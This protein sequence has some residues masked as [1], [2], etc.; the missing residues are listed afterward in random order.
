MALAVFVLVACGGGG[1]DEKPP[2]EEETMLVVVESN[3][4]DASFVIIDSKG[5]EHSGGGRIYEHKMPPGSVSIA[6]NFLDNYCTPGLQTRT[7]SSG[8][9]VKFSA[10]YDLGCNA[11]LIVTADMEN[12]K[13]MLFGPEKTYRGLGKEWQIHGIP[14][15]QYTI[16][17]DALDDA[18]YQPPVMQTI[19]IVA[20]STEQRSFSYTFDDACIQGGYVFKDEDNDGFSDGTRVPVDGPEDVSAYRYPS[21]LI[22]TDGDCDDIDPSENPVSS[23]QYCTTRDGETATVFSEDFEAGWGDWS[24]DAGVWEIGVPTAG[25][26][27]SQGGSQCAGTILDGNY[28]TYTSSRLI[29]PAITLPAISGSNDLSLRFMHWFEYYPYNISNSQDF[30]EIEIQTYDDASGWSDWIKIDETDQIQGTNPG[31]SLKSLDISMYAGQ[32]V[33]ICFRH[34]SDEY[35]VRTGWYVDDV[36][37]IQKTPEFEGTFE[38][39]WSDWFA[40]RGVWQNGTPT[41]GPAQCHAGTLCMGTIMEGNYPTYTIS[42]LI[43]PS[44]QLPTV[45]TSNELHLRFWQWFD[46]YP[47]DV[48]NSQDYG[49]VQIQTYNVPTGWSEWEAAVADDLVQNTSNAWTRKDVDLTP[50]VGQTVRIAFR[51]VSD[52]YAVRTGWYVDDVQF[53]ETAP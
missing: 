51:H 45:N 43:S 49:E 18:C 5:D 10:D 7:G 13:F 20:G 28:P 48:S 41:V 52:E 42:R 16:Y 8:D 12:A 15:G 4:E 26:T 33:R 23:R 50:F 31:W 38:S 53:V 14:A 25:P 40:D 21:E 1:A 47:Y 46:Y 35:A 32:Q 6:F 29:S 9:I 24:A 34:V 19:T 39:G 3:Q 17:F 37:I 30:G 11:N 22:S 36:Q 27:A 2:P 44:I